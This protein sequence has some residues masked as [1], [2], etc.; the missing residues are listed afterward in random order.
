MNRATEI[1]TLYGFMHLSVYRARSSCA[2][3]IR[4]F[5]TDILKNH[6]I[7]NGNQT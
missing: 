3:F 7:C 6:Y 4:N 1:F 5:F 2:R